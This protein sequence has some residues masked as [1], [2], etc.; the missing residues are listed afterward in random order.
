MSKWTTRQKVAFFVCL[1]IA[2]NI[3]TIGGLGFFFYMGALHV[4]YGKM[5]NFYVAADDNDYEYFNMTVSYIVRS[6]KYDSAFI[7][8]DSI[9]TVDFYNRYA[10]RY[11]EESVKYLSYYYGALQVQGQ[12]YLTLLENGFFDKAEE[13]GGVLTVYSHPEYWWHEWNCPLIAV[14]IGDE[15]YLDFETGKQNWLDWLKFQREDYSF[16]QTPIKE[17]ND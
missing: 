3:L 2:A 10:D 16:L 8:V 11:T 15:V 17:Q 12:S 14:S 4:D 6:E 1:G 5:Y 13:E 9:D 7:Y